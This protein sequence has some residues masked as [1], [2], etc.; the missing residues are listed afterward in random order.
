MK[1]LFLKHVARQCSASSRSRTR[2]AAAELAAIAARET[3]LSDPAWTNFQGRKLVELGV[4]I[5]AGTHLTESSHKAPG[6]LVRVHLL[7]RDGAIASLM[8]SGDFTCLP[9]DG[10]ER[11]A[12]SLAGTRLQPAAPG[13]RGRRGRSRR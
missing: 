6:G 13:R 11:L 8:L 3:E 5:A 2:R 9:E 4:K 12:A 1:Q 10:V 7:A